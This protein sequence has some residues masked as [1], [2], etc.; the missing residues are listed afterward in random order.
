LTS[1]YFSCICFRC[2]DNIKSRLLS[3]IISR[4]LISLIHSSKRCDK[5]IAQSFI[6]IKWERTYL[7]QVALQPKSYKI[8]LI[9]LASQSSYTR[10]RRVAISIKHGSKW[11]KESIGFATQ[12]LIHPTRNLTRMTL[13]LSF[14]KR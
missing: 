12:W 7:Q 4:T 2:F 3:D 13:Q 5:F 6:L 8:F 9:A 1:S 10:K 14:F 11:K